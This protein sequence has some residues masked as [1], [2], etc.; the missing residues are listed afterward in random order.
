MRASEK[1]QL[2]LRGSRQCAFYWTIDEP[3]ALPLKFPKGWLETR[4]F[5]FCVVF[6]IFIAGNHRHF[7]FGVQIDHSKCL[8]VCLSVCHKLEFYKNGYRN[9][10]ITQTMCI[11]RDSIFLMLK[12]LANF[13][14]SNPQWGRQIEVW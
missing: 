3:C 4:I 9:R 7:K 6:H 14:R 1:V 11:A 12:I 8:S 10:R 2:S 5:A 13:Q